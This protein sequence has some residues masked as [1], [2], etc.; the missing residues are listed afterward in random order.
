MRKSLYACIY[1]SYCNQ[2]GPSLLLCERGHICSK[3][4]LGYF[5]VAHY[6]KLSICQPQAPDE[7]QTCTLR[8]DTQ[9]AP[10][11]SLERQ[12]QRLTVLSSPPSLSTFFFSFLGWRFNACCGSTGSEGPTFYYLIDEVVQ[13]NKSASWDDKWTLTSVFTGAAMISCLLWCIFEFWSIDVGLFC[14][15]FKQNNC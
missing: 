1:C 11:Q 6:N 15:I 14:Y 13:R 10:V 5:T 9:P 7:S 4:P 8:R 2:H 3:P 12:T